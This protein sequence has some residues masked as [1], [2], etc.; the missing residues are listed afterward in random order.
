[1]RSNFLFNGRIYARTV[2]PCSSPALRY[3]LNMTQS[4]KEARILYGR[5]ALSSPTVRKSRTAGNGTARNAV[6]LLLRSLPTDQ[7]GVEQPIP[8]LPLEELHLARVVAWPGRIAVILFADLN[9]A[10]SRIHVGN[11]RD[12][13]GT[14]ENLCVHEQVT[15]AWLGLRPVEMRNDGR[16]RS[17]RHPGVVV[18][19]APDIDS[20]AHVAKHYATIHQQPTTGK[21]YALPFDAGVGPTPAI[22]LPYNAFGTA[23]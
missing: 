5:P 14:E 8:I 6:D 20:I 2:S 16:D 10:R 3:N 19:P 11:D 1:M 4:P 21:L 15:D 9:E 22:G 12:M 7:I 13:A 18:Y 17:I 23:V